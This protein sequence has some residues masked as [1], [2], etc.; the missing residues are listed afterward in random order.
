MKIKNEPT[1]SQSDDYNNNETP[2]KR[3][4]VRLIILGIL[5]VGTIYSIFLYQANLLPVDDYIGTATHP[6]ITLFK[7]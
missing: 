6:G 2:E 7:H 1:L 4:A 5:A 3:R